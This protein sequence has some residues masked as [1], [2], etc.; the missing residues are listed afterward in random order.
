MKK[1]TLMLLVIQSGI[2]MAQTKTVLAPTGQK[3]TIHP[4]VN[5]GLTVSDGN[6]KL[7]GSLIK[8]TAITTD[9]TNTLAITGLTTSNDANDAPIVL[10]A[11]G[12]LKKGAFPPYQYSAH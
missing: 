6:V 9:A 5:N 11:D 12:T 4:N 3:I 7:G 8:P 10:A 1:I 2:I